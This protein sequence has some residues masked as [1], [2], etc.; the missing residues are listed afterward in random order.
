MNTRLGWIGSLFFAC[1]VTVF[2]LSFLGLYS[3]ES[4]VHA[5]DH[6]LIDSNSYGVLDFF[7]V[8]I[9]DLKQV[10]VIVTQGPIGC[11]SMWGNT[12]GQVMHPFEVAL[13]N[14]G[15]GQ[16]SSFTTDSQGLSGGPVT[17][18]FD[19][20]N[21]W[22]NLDGVRIYN[23]ESNPVAVAVTAIFRGQVI[24][25]LW[26]AIMYLGLFLSGTGIVIIGVAV[27]KRRH[28]LNSESKQQG[29]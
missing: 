6:L 29:I 15:A 25:G 7:H 26:Q 13:L 21:G 4:D 22:T 27:Y 8:Q 9:A 14:L 16:V 18:V 23:P 28:K 20:P 19:F 1:G 24:N 2:M 11:Y 10:E 17:H 12:T 5:S 3:L